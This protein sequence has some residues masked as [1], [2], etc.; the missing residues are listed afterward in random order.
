MSSNEKL[1]VGQVLWLKLK[2]ERDGEYS[3][4]ERPYLI[5]K[6]DKTIRLVRLLQFDSIKGDEF[7]FL[8]EK[9]YVVPANEPTEKVIF[10]DS[11]YTTR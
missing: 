9:M 7:E 6:I 11:L 8:M 3:D 4:I 2:F 10:K 1:E 5:Y